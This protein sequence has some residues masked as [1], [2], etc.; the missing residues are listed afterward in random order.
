MAFMLW[1]RESVIEA[2]RQVRGSLTLP[3]HGRVPINLK[4]ARL[5]KGKV[6]PVGPSETGK[7]YEDDAVSAPVAD[8]SARA[9]RRDPQAYAASYGQ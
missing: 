4:I 3:S 6:E 2:V 9:A 1:A 7:L 5:A 8:R